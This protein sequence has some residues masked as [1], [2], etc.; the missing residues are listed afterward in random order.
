MERGGC[1]T[2][3]NKHKVVEIRDIGEYTAWIDALKV[4]KTNKHH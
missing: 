1:R 4:L 2:T 3:S